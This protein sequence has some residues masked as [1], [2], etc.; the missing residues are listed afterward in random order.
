MSD[1]Q[2]PEY[3][4]KTYRPS[5]RIQGSRNGA[6]RNHPVPLT[7]EDVIYI[8]RALDGGAERAA[9]ARRYGRAESTIS[10][11]A[12]GRQWRHVPYLPPETI[13]DA[14]T[15]PPRGR[16]TVQEVKTEEERKDEH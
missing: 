4:S 1:Q 2:Q 3:R 11:I 7:E 16:V 14:D 10:K 12:S 9:L 6:A 13:V 8:R 15:A 5:V